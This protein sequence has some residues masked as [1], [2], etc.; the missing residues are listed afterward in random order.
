MIVVL[1]TALIRSSSNHQ[2][3]KRIISFQSFFWISVITQNSQKSDDLAN[4][5]DYE[6]DQSCHASSVNEPSTSAAVALT[7]AT[8]A[9]PG[10]A[11]ISAPIP[12]IVETAISSTDNS[13]NQLSVAIQKYVPTL[14]PETPPKKPQGAPSYKF[15]DA[16]DGVLVDESASLR[17]RTPF[18]A[19]SQR[20]CGSQQSV[21]LNVATPRMAPKWRKCAGSTREKR[22]PR[23]NTSHNASFLM[24]DE[25]PQAHFTDF[26]EIVDYVV[27]CS[28][29]LRRDSSR[30]QASVASA[31]CT[32]AK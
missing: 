2:T 1:S 14:R 4:P 25:L 17:S 13:L 12:S 32:A 24:A 28:S 8:K 7:T 20:L 26:S 18:S 19:S 30:S 27:S 10:S 9:T 11:P 3:L 5:R 29:S 15:V 6:H 22:L 31:T 21:A 23:Q 16:I